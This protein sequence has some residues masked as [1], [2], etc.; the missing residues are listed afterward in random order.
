MLTQ[1]T[2]M[3][4]TRK[5]LINIQIGYVIAYKHTERLCH[6]RVLGHFCTVE[7]ELDREQAN[8]KFFIKLTPEQYQSLDSQPSPVRYHWTM[9][10]I[11]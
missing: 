5:V 11:A 1:C 6:S 8:E 3:W 2:E 7:A 4:H 9:A 10:N